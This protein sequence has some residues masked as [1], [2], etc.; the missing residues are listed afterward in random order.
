MFLILMIVSTMIVTVFTIRCL[1][2]LNISK[3][4]A[5]LYLVVFFIISILSLY[6]LLNST[7]RHN[8]ALHQN[9]P[10]NIIV[11]TSGKE[12]PLIYMNHGMP[13]GL[14]VDVI[15][16]VAH[17]MK[18]EVF[19][20]QLPQVQL[21]NAL[22]DGDIDIIVDGIEWNKKNLDL[23]HFSNPY[24]YLPLVF[25]GIPKFTITNQAKNINALAL[26]VN[27]DYNFGVYRNARYVDNLKQ[28]FSG[29]HSMINYYYNW[30]ILINDM[31]EH[32][33]DFGVA[34]IQTITNYL[35]NE[36]HSGIKMFH[37]EPNRN[38][39]NPVSLAFAKPF[40]DSLEFQSYLHNLQKIGLI[41]QLYQKYF[42]IS[43]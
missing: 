32:D 21:E 38:F 1:H 40:Q 16:I 37:I 12:Y 8:I 3:T 26:T 35:Y 24:L 31:I 36:S 2:F 17:N 33:L 6:L 9:N 39:D 4:N 20:I 34:N 42:N 7:M 23:V 22:H 43:S 19:F 13:E 29:N 15:E 11:G 14:V 28:S 41:E 5:L 27:N 25:F 10:N 18:K 30:D